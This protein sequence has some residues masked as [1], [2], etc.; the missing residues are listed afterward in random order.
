MSLGSHYS[1]ISYC[2]HENPDVLT[3][4]YKWKN[5]KPPSTVLHQGLMP[6]ETSLKTTEGQT[7]IKAFHLH[8]GNPSSLV[9]LSIPIISSSTAGLPIPPTVDLVISR[10]SFFRLIPSAIILVEEGGMACLVTEGTAARGSWHDP[11]LACPRKLILERQK[12]AQDLSGFY[13]SIKGYC[14]QRSF[15]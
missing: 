15:Y 7:F 12:R 6:N 13:N 11:W 8:V 3:R 2:L 9:T 4:V 5:G 14:C 1:L 10:R